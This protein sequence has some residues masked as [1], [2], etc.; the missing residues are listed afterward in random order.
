MAQ[1]TNSKLA[2]VANVDKNWDVFVY[3]I[4]N[5]ESP[6]NKNS[7]QTL[8]NYKKPLAHLQRIT[9]TPY[10]EKEPS[11]AADG[12]SLVYSTTDGLIHTI[13]LTSQKQTT[14]KF[15][16]Q[17]SKY[18][19]PSFSP[20]GSR[21]VMAQ[22]KNSKIDDS[23]L[24]IY[25]LKGEKVSTFLTQGSSQL[26]PAWSPD[27]K[28]I[29]Y[30]NVHCA[31]ECG[32][33]IQELWLAQVNG[34]SAK[35]L[36]LTDAHSMHPVW[37]PDGQKIAF[38]SN[39]KGNF[40]IFIFH[41]HDKTLQQVTDDKSFDNNPAWSRDGEKIAFIST[42][43]GGTMAIWMK[44]LETGKLTKLCPFSDHDIDCKDISWH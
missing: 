2:F 1:Q 6:A 8:N 38:S 7:N 27:G 41:L 35:Q 5:E 26:Y 3:T 43:S 24:A 34:Q 4:P 37:S 44:E 22:F 42:R 15:E 23:D 39:M 18:L 40:D 11:W 12:N 29:A 31:L 20:D 33:I 32:H 28:K 25:N 36:L 17:E 19:H 21:V 14:L 16:N 13:D 10:D 9:K 30:T